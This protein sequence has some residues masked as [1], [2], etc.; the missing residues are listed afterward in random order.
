MYLF[1][2]LFHNT[3]RNTF[4]MPMHYV[5]IINDKRDHGFERDQGGG[6]G[7]VLREKREEDNGIVIL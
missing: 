3:F 4:A 7:S 1:P 5:I 6:Y 2:H